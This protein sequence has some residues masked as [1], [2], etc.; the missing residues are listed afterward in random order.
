MDRPLGSSRVPGQGWDVMTDP[1]REQIELWNG[2]FGPRWV[3]HQ[4]SLDRVWGPLGDATIECATVLTGERVLDVGCGCG[5]TALQL[6]E[7]V[8]PAGSVVGIDV[9]GPMLARAR[10]R[11]EVL[12]IANVRF[13]NADASTYTS[14]VA[15]N[16]VFSRAGIMFFRDP[17]GAFANLR[18]V[19]RPGGRLAFVCF[20][21]QG[22]NPWWTVPLAAV[23]PIAKPE[24][25]AVS[26]GPGVFSLADARRLRAVIEQSGF[27]DAAYNP[28]DFDLLLGTDIE[29]AT[30][31]SINA[32]AAAKALAS[33]DGKLRARGR[34]AISQ[35]LSRNAGPNGVTLRAATW[36]VLARN[37]CS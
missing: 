36:I 31:F 9:S 10:E 6:T 20:R 16:L 17:I 34:L 8:G 24:T 27:V 4:E 37:P 33:L 35:S 22:L 5:A 14:D 2:V 28:V 11:A 18:H 29:S 32:G 23:A 26:D 1:N 21:D 25:P 7:R 12:G 30:E 15:F 13:V 3:A 19:L